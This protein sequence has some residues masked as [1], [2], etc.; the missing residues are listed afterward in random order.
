[1]GASAIGSARSRLRVS[2]FLHANHRLTHFRFVFIFIDA[3]AAAT[4]TAASAAAALFP[5][6]PVLLLL[7]SLVSLFGCSVRGDLCL[8]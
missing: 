2:S 7:L 5:L 3:A 4:A 8:C 1:V 6:A